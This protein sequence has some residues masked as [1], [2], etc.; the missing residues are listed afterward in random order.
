MPVRRTLVATAVLALGLA[1]A[2]CSASSSDSAGSASGPVQGA[3]PPAAAPEADGGTLG[4]ESGDRSGDASGSVALDRSIVVIASTTVRVD[5]VTSAT[6]RLT[7][8]VAGAG[9]RI[10]SQQVSRGGGPVDGICVDGTDCAPVPAPG[11][12]AS[13]TTVRLPTTE[14][15]TFLRSTAGLGTVESGTRSSTDVSA[16]VADVDARLRS[17]EASLARVRALLTRAESIADVV[18]LEGELARRQADLEALQARQRVLDDQTA[19]A[20][21]TVALVERDA[22]IPGDEDSGFLAG[23]SAGWDAFASATVVGLT[24]LGAVL[25]F[26]AFAAVIGLAVWVVVRR[27]R[28]HAPAPTT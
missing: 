22:T 2:G 21:V 24:V 27:S 13:T 19:Q 16:E 26:A 12:A 5:D 3:A 1:L 14:V 28:R 6:D 23:L 20:T 4:S 17:A 10:E 7:T 25:P 18:A 9:G 11:Y 8:L 15:D